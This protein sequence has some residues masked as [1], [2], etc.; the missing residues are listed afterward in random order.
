MIKFKPGDQVYIK[1]ISELRTMWKTDRHGTFK[2]PNCAIA[3]YMQTFCD[4]FDTIESIHPS[5][6]PLLRHSGYYWPPEALE[7]VPEADT[8]DWAELF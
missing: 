2:V 4:S 6:C 5:G 3:P 1:P 8:D 7:L